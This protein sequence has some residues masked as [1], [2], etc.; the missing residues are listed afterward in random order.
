MDVSD[1]AELFTATLLNLTGLVQ[2][3]VLSLLKNVKGGGVDSD[4]E[5]E[6][7][8]LRELESILVQHDPEFQEKV[9]LPFIDVTPCSTPVSAFSSVSCVPSCNE[10]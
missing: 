5:R 2:P 8:R 10:G 6:E 3:F 9:R 1:A 7:G 4:A